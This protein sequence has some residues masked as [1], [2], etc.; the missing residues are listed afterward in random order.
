MGKV[1]NF[2]SQIGNLNFGQTT[3]ELVV[4]CPNKYHKYFLK[5]Y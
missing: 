2:K 1:S 5:F 3:G 4:I